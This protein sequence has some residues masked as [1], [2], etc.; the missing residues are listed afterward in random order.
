MG[1]PTGSGRRRRET[2]LWRF[3]ESQQTLWKKKTFF[4]QSLVTSLDA[5]RRHESIWRG[6]R[7]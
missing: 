3:G 7:P 4:F 5:Q 1:F 2:G 6:G